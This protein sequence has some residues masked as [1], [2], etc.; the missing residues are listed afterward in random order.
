MQ[1][2]IISIRCYAVLLLLLTMFSCK[3]SG[4]IIYDDTAGQE[5]LHVV[6]FTM[7]G[8]TATTTTLSTPPTKATNAIGDTLKN[9]A[10]N[11]YYRVYN[12][13]GIWIK[14]IDQKSTDVNFGNIT[15]RL[16]AGT[17]KIFVAASKTELRVPGKDFA[18]NN[19]YYGPIEYNA[20]W[21]DAFNKAFDLSV[22]NADVS[23]NIRLERA[24]A[25]CQIVLPDGLPKAVTQ[26]KIQFQGDNNNV[27]YVTPVNAPPVSSG[28][29]KTI[30]LKFDAANYKAGAK[31]F[32]FFIANTATP[33]KFILSA[34]NSAGIEL[35]S[36]SIDNIQFERNKMTTLTGN[37][38]PANAVSDDFV[39]GINPNWTDGRTEKF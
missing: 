14:S 15:D 18:Y 8:L 21:T 9:Y 25:G 34:Y 35:L 13:N 16:A 29:Y 2:V 36:K 24:V 37:L 17:Y 12:A 7:S 11:L 6:S 39:I 19:S 33:V 1:K 30:D 10:D 27:P 20:V 26:L 23:Q 22:G 32:T 28:L 31:T 5:P 4:P 3:K 38:F